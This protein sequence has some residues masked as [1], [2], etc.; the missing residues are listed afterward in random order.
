MMADEIGKNLHEA[1]FKAKIT[2]RD[3]VK[4]AR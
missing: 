3:I 1:G 4:H 2:H